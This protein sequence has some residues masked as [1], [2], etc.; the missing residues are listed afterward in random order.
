MRVA[1]IG[2]GYVG[3]VSGACFA[4]F[5]H[6]V[7]CVDKDAD[8]IAVWLTI[9]E[10]N[11]K[12]WGCKRIARHLNELGI[13]SPG[14]G[15]LRTDQ[16]VR[17][18]VSGKWGPNTVK[19]LCENAI[20]AGATRLDVAVDGGGTTRIRVVDDG[21]HVIPKTEVRCHHPSSG[22]EMVGETDIFGEAGSS[23]SR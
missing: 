23:V 4:D 22:L 16:G 7:V 11:H 9:L 19:E 5:G 2:T 13:P 12:G 10:L 1:M 14:A 17:H 8:K 20:D 6:H 15:T 3:L 18:R 21:H